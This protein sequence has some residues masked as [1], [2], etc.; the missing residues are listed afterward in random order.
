MI[1]SKWHNGIQIF[2]DDQTQETVHVNA[3]VYYKDDFIGPG[4]T[5]VPAAG[6]AESG[7]DWVKKNVGAGAIT[8]VADQPGGWLQGALDSTSQK[9][10]AGLYMNDE[11]VFDVTKG[12]VFEARILVPVIPTLESE[13]I[14]G[15]ID[16]WT[17]GLPDSATYQL[18]FNLDGAASIR[19]QM[20]DN[21]NDLDVDST[22]DCA[23]DTWR[24]LQ[25]DCSEADEVLFRIDGNV[26]LHG[27]N[28]FNYAA[29][30]ANAILQPYIG[31]YKASGAGLGTFKVD[32]VRCWQKRE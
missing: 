24:I 26:V 12:L 6:A 28:R 1:R 2:F 4:Y 8:Q 10:E 25:I 17:D 31:V 13:I 32:Y 11:R 27:T 3:P 29:T 23:T 22:L 15:L 5:T 16:D 20:D 30:G 7:M 21:V 14:V 9:A 18:S 19:C